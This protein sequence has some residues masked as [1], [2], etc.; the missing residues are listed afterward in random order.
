MRH[1]SLL[2]T[3]KRRPLTAKP[4]ARPGDTAWRTA[5]A[6]R[7]DLLIDG[8][9][10]YAALDRALDL[11][12]EQLWIVGW[13]FN[14]DIRLR[15]DCEESPTLGAR[16][17]A[18][19]EAKPGLTIRILVWAM[20]PIY[21]GKSLKMFSG[22]G[23]NEHPRIEI[24]FDTRHAIRGSHHQKL[25]VIDDR[26][27]FAGG[28]DLTA[29]RWDTP[30]HRPDDPH[31]TLPDGG[32][33][34]PV[35]DAQSV[36]EGAAAA[37]IGD[38]ARRRWLRANRQRIAPV[39]RAGDAAP[40]IATPVFSDIPVSLAR[41]EPD[42]RGRK[43][44]N[45]AMRLTLAALARAR[46]HIYIENQY[47]ASRKIARLLCEKLED[48][49]GPEV[50]IITTRSSHGFLER[51]VLGANRDRLLR[52]L[53]ASDHYGRLRAGFP[54]VPRADG[55]SEEVNVHSKIIVVDDVFL[56]VG[57]SNFNQRS[58]KL[59]SELDLAIETDRAKDRTALRALRARLF[60]EHLGAS[61]EVMAAVLEGNGSLTEAFDQLNVGPRG[62]RPFEDARKAGP[63]DLVIGTDLVDPREPWWP[64]PRLFRL[65]ARS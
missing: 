38:I 28:I 32:A 2:S 24:C 26:I 41:T 27:A 57:S 5:T 6:D 9:A 46:R 40:F 55:T 56:R 19:A 50:V 43:G 45:E 21:S 29:K 11:A 44:R 33:Y 12:E 31:R 8:A 20:G 25:V 63:T 35:H 58:E 37:A 54:V 7:F 42:L 15:P 18:L 65:F 36:V 52:K 62:L 39:R 23:W 51:L 64:L 30:E 47:F 49:N 13:D 14:P 16:L 60:A 59:D 3:F 34:G 53:I 61:Q 1:D 22:Q 10:Y 48:P 17:L 4:I